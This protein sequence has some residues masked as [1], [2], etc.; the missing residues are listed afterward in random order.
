M[1]DIRIKIQEIMKPYT[2]AESRIPL[3]GIML[4]EKEID[5]GDEEI[6]RIGQRFLELT[7][8]MRDKGSA[9]E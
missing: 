4:I 7:A 2:T 6:L 3:E 5:I 8:D 9:K 1:M